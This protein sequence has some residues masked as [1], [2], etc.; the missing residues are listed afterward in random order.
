MTQLLT[1]FLLLFH[2]DGRVVEVTQ[3]EFSVVWRSECK[4][5]T[6]ASPM[7]AKTVHEGDSIRV[8]FNGDRFE[9]IEILKKHYE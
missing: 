7:L 8:F 4:L 5:V 2:F 3:Y 6:I 1:L 9:G